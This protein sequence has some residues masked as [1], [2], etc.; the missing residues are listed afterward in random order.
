LQGVH[1]GTEAP[2]SMARPARGQRAES[3]L[4][5]DLQANLGSPAFGSLYNSVYREYRIHVLF[6]K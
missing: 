5:S 2:T 1:L 4:P 6:E 3:F